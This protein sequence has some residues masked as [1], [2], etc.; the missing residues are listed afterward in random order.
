MGP[1]ENID[2]SGAS[3]NHGGNKFI[4]QA[5]KLILNY[6][7]SIILIPMLVVFILGYDVNYDFTI[8]PLNSMISHLYLKL[9]QE[10]PNYQKLQQLTQDITTLN[11]T[12][13]S[14][15]SDNLL[16]GES[17][18]YL[19]SCLL[20]FTNETV[21]SPI[22]LWVLSN[23]RTSTEHLLSVIN[24]NSNY[25]LNSL[26]IDRVDFVNH[27]ITKAKV[28]HLYI[29]HKNPIE[30]SGLVDLLSRNYGS[31]V[32]TID[33]PAIVKEFVKYYLF[34]NESRL[35]LSKLPGTIVIFIVAILFLVHLFLSISNLHKV[36][37]NLG[38]L[39]AWSVLVLISSTAAVKTLEI[40]NGNTKSWT[41]VF[42]P[43]N[44][45]TM[46]I[47]IFTVAMISSRNLIRILTDLSS[48]NYYS[49]STK[50]YQAKLYKFF[51]GI[52]NTWDVSYEKLTLIS[53]CFGVINLNYNIKIPNVSKVL[54]L[55]LLTLKLTE[56]LGILLLDHY[57]YGN[58]L[59]VF[60]L[61]INNYYNAVLVALLI[62][63]TLQLTALIGVISIDNHR[64]DVTRILNDS[65]DDD[66]FSVDDCEYDLMNTNG[67]SYFL[68]K[69]KPSRS[70]FCYRLG[71]SLTFVRHPTSLK[72]WIIIL[73]TLQSFNLSILL[74]MWS[75]FVPYN[76]YNYDN[77]FINWLTIDQE[78]SDVFYCL[79][80][81]TVILLIFSLSFVVFKLSNY[82]PTKFELTDGSSIELNDVKQFNTIELS[83]HSLDVLKLKAGESSFL[84]SIGLDH[85]VLIWSPLT[86]GTNDASRPK[87]LD[88]SSTVK[89]N[90]GEVEFWPINFTDISKNGEFI[91][92]INHRFNII[93]CYCRLLLK[94]I[95][96][97]P[98]VEK[99]NGKILESFFR[100][101]TVPGFLKLKMI[102]RLNLLN[103]RRPSEVSINGNFPHSIDE[104]SDT[105]GIKL[106]FTMVL[107]SGSIL[108]YSCKD[109]EFKIH[110]MLNEIYPDTKDLKL[111]S[112]K[113]LI[114]P[115]LNDRIVCQVN[116]NDL[117]VCTV[118]NNK[119]NFSLLE[120]RE[121]NYNKEVIFKPSSVPTPSSMSR[122]SSMNYN[123]ESLPLTYDNQDEIS[124]TGRLVS[125]SKTTINIAIVVPMEFVGMI[126]RVNNLVAELIDIQTGTIMKKFNVG[127]FKPSSFRV[128]HLEPTHCRFCGC[129]SIQSLSILYEAFDTKTLIIH[130]FKIENNRSKNS[131][132]L[133]VERDPREIRCV[134]FSD[135]IEDQLWFEDI[136]KWEVSDINMIIGLKR[137]TEGDNENNND[138]SSSTSISITHDVNKG[139][140]QRRNKMDNSTKTG[141][142]A[143]KWRGFI[144]TLNDGN[145][146]DYDIPNLSPNVISNR[147]NCI[148]K[149]GFKSMAISFGNLI[150]ILYLGNHKLIEENLYFNDLNK[151]KSIN[152]ELLFINKRRRR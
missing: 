104:D 141:S 149:F 80:F 118:V 106:D 102:Q 121:D 71:T 27:L 135:V 89:A 3:C 143:K 119:W 9:N 60:H 115:R 58:F 26:Y 11:L 99:A 132:C 110:N 19:H 85:K 114:T 122:M 21:L 37:S 146:I 14:I 117:V 5:I 81:L 96:E 133:R 70:S 17:I 63:H 59:E 142:T 147:I 88:I 18:M 56:R 137:E 120:P 84:L 131:I 62:D 7:K 47:Y 36:R 123:F 39:F 134:G 100:E 46:S 129:A 67:I 31:L 34:T 40:V 42:E 105:G 103:K 139:L 138:F 32:T 25:M 55:D 127:H 45:V 140:H 98:F 97:K 4:L 24:H 61:K 6:P 1:I 78:S 69:N 8:L 75:L 76:L 150:Q 91:I 94:F 30:L 93:R 22:N 54:F 112:A 152:N 73:P 68:L 38:M 15:S 48:N 126:V 128:A 20:D 145:M 101:K 86:N 144:I 130:S 64:R 66:S 52:N 57:F 107:D 2:K 43:A 12:R 108:T 33:N 90:F 72:S 74:L 82:K 77:H 95:W 79:E 92:L 109:G 44:L 87:W 125:N 136:A 113:K 151:N 10:P 124:D 29:I 13:L 111:I 65:L 35:S 28:L 41:Q 53:K 23:G 51:I 16:T 148:E 49:N 83:C 116:N 50:N